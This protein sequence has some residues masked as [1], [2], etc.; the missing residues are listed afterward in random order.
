MGVSGYVLSRLMHII[1][2]LHCIACVEGLWKDER[3][4]E[5]REREREERETERGRE[6]DRQTDR[7]RETERESLNK[8]ERN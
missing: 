6:R 5:E 3:E 2:K 8:G 4:R 1:I 7:E